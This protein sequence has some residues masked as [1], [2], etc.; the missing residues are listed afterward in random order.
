M[1]IAVNRWTRVT[2]IA[3]L[4]ASEAIDQLSEVDPCASAKSRLRLL[5][6]GDQF[7]VGALSE[8]DAVEALESLEAA[9]EASLLSTSVR[10]P[11]ERE[12]LV[13]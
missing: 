6:I 8:S 7:E 13:E 3:R 1:T 4:A 2:L 5:A 11:R 10:T 9:A 12:T